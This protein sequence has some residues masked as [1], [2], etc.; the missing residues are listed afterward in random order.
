MAGQKNSWRNGTERKPGPEGPGRADLFFRPDP[1][2]PRWVAPQQSPTPFHRA[3]YH[4]SSSYCPVLK[5][6]IS[7]YR[8]RQFKIDISAYRVAVEKR[9]KEALEKTQPLV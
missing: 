2:I 8:V 4:Y 7:A 1:A 9:Q 6:D 3:T 5:N